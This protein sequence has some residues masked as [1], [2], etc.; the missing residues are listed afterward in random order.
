MK[1]YIQRL[2]DN[3]PTY[4]FVF[5]WILR[6]TLLF[7]FVKGFF[8]A[9]GEA[10]DITD[11]LQVG[12]K[13]LCTF[14]WE[15]F[16]AFPKKSIFRHIASGFQSALMVMIWCGSFGGKFLNLYYDFRLLSTL[17]AAAHAYFSAMRL[18]VQ[19]SKQKNQLHP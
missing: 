18:Y 17:S 4:R 11:P 13:F 9:E 1:E 2:K 16:M 6:A 12:A 15:I 8:P 7:A 14:A 10:F 3:C 19:F 5:W